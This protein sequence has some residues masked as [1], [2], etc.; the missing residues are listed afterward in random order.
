MR[1]SQVVSERCLSLTV[2]RTVLYVRR[3]RG[4][5]I[6]EKGDNCMDKEELLY[7]KIPFATLF[8]FR[9]DHLFNSLF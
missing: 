2:L 8:E 9:V 7:C 5:R 1:R 4:H 6:K 3:Q